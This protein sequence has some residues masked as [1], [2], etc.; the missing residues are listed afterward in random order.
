MRVYNEGINTSSVVH[1]VV[2]TYGS[3]PQLLGPRHEARITIL[4]DAPLDTRDAV[5][6]LGLAGDPERQRALQRAVLHRGP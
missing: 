5:N 1:A 6:P 2:Y 3:Y 4:R